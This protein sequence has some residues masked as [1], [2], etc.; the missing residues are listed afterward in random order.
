VSDTAA[1]P[2]DPRLDRLSAICLELP[3]AKREVSGRHAAFRVRGR[4]FAYF[5]DDHHGDGIVGLNAKAAPGIAEA[6]IDDAPDRFYRPAYLGHRGWVG[7]RLDTA[8]F[9]W[10]EV[11]GVVV[12]SYRLCAPK[13]LARAIDAG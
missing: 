2:L 1:E 11:A 7:L 6:L 8:G 3:E 12:E 4:T 13:S 10:D 9:D 5:L